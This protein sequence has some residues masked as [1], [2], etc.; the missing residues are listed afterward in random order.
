[1]LQLSAGATAFIFV[2]NSIVVYLKYET[3]PLHIEYRINRDADT[4][5][6]CRFN[7]WHLCPLCRENAYER[8]RS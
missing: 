8:K 6:P 7:L 1:M 4:A 3:V 5:Q 2:T